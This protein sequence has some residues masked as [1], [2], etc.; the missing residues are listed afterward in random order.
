MLVSGGTLPAKG[1]QRQCASS[2][3]MLGDGTGALSNVCS[4]LVQILVT[5]SS[6]HS[7]FVSYN[8]RFQCGLFTDCSEVGQSYCEHSHSNILSLVSTG[9]LSSYL[10][11]E[12]AELMVFFLDCGGFLWFFQQLRDFPEN[13]D[14]FHIIFTTTGKGNHSA[15]QRNSRKARFL[16]FFFLDAELVQFIRSFNF[17]GENAQKGQQGAHV[18]STQQD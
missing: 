13:L 5:H 12:L 1:A 16:D 15:L 4:I 14:S 10:W 6:A 2:S 7:V 18:P 11:K 8:R 17:A 3:Q 9:A